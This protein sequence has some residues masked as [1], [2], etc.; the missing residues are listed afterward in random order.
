MGAIRTKIQV[1]KLENNFNRLKNDLILFIFN[2]SSCLQLNAE[3]KDKNNPL[4]YEKALM[5]CLGFEP[6]ATERKAYS[7]GFP[8][9]AT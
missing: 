7:Y 3:F 6:G 9:T 5:L 4:H 8:H 1:Y 2:F